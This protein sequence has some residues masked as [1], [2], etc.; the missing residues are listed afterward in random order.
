M[1]KIIICLV[2]VLAALPLAAQRGSIDTDIFGDLQFRSS[3][4]RYSASLKKDI[5]DNLSF[6]DS[7]RNKIVF[8]KKYL[9]EEY[10]AVLE[11]E[12]ARRDFFRSIVS[13]HRGDEGY[14]ARLSADI[15]G[16]VITEDNRGNRTEEKTDIFG[17]KSYEETRDGTK[18][19]ISR[20][21]HGTLQY[22]H[23]NKSASLGTAFHMGKWVY[24]DNDGNRLEFGERTWNGMIRRFGDDER[25]F[26]FLIDQFLESV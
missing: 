1:K 15:F 5:F 18:M 16:T 13:R 21:M 19:S 17:N 11:N 25:I 8:D 7:R 2:L 3:D 24:E 26:L 6:T 10:P 4:L 9:A 20:D 22:R 12:S 14:E 23:G